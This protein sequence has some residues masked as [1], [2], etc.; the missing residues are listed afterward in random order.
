MAISAVRM[1][2]PTGETNL[3]TSDLT[4]PDANTVMNQLVKETDTGIADA[5]A[6]L[7]NSQEEITSIK[8]KAVDAT[9]RTAKGVQGGIK[10]ISKMTPREIDA[11][12]GKMIPNPQAQSVFNKLSASCKK[13]FSAEGL[14]KPWDKK[15]KCGSGSS[16]SGKNG[17]CNSGEFGDVLNKMTGGE[18][19][20]TFSDA[21]QALQ[22]LVS[23]SKYGLN[24]GMCGVFGALA[25][26]VDKN[27][28]SRAL[29]SL[30]STA[31]LT[32]NTKG[33]LDLA[34]SAPGL[35]PLLENPSAVT[36]SLDS[37]TIPDDISRA[38]Y[39]QFAEQFDGSMELLDENWDQS[40]YDDMI[41]IEAAETG[42]DDLADA[43]GAL[44]QNN[45]FDETNLEEARC[46]PEFLKAV[47]FDAQRNRNFFAEANGLVSV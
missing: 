32:K 41:S 44:A 20:S 29:G 42:T 31:G 15:I 18:Y 38:D 13:K 22:N 5:N 2:I 28:A 8:D 37:F 11:R 19:G 21:S 1:K 9:V 34:K 47:G 25:G 33:I 7:T 45:I 12:V 14:G 16:V 26:D 30:L 6:F 4:S 40:K 46:D 10:D 24:A 23:M 35:H 17:S 43:Y 27:V 36:S 39:S 3:P